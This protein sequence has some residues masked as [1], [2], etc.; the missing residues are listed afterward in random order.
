MRL[1]QP[2]WLRNDKLNV[3]ASLEGAKQSKPVFVVGA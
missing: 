2:F 1:L 3:I